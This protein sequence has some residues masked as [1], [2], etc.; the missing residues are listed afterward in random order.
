MRAIASAKALSEKIG[1]SLEV[2]W[3]LDSN[4]GASF[5]DLFEPLETIYVRDYPQKSPILKRIQTLKVL[6][7]R[8]RFL[9]YI[10]NRNYDLIFNQNQMITNALEDENSINSLRGKNVLLNSYAKFYKPEFLSFS[11][12]HP[13]K[14]LEEEINSVAKNFN[15]HTVGVH[16]RRKDNK[17]S[18]YHSPVELFFQVLEDRIEK[19]S[20]FNFF[21]ATDCPE[22]ESLFVSKYGERVYVK[23]KEYVR[24]TTR[25][26]QCA[27]IDLYLLSKT[28]EIFSSYWSSFSQTATEIG[29]IPKY[30]VKE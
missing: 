27:V 24:T 5:C 28:K 18:I 1:S 3:I 9:N 6:K 16:I 21:L 7:S 12:F 20:D 13:L 17:M 4:L 25:G 2:A 23:E 8:F 29:N 30:T 26:I 19:Q 22:T 11:L 14:F 10:R 15:E